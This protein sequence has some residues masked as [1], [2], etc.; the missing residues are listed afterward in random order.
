[1]TNEVVT[2]ATLTY[3]RA[4]LL[5]SQLEASGIECFLSNINVIRSAIGTGVKVKVR[6]SD[7]NNA[8][9][10]VLL[11][12]EEYGKDELETHDIVEDITKVLVP[13]DFSDYSKKAC[14]Y[15]LGIADRLQAEITFMHSYYFDMMPLVNFSEPYTYQINASQS[16][17]DIK[18]R[19]EEEMLGLKEEMLREAH[20]KQYE[21]INL[22]TYLTHGIPDKEI[23][24]YSK[25]Y[26]PGVIIMGTKIHSENSNQF[27]GNVTATVLEE[28]KVPVLTIP[29]KSNFSGVNKTN[30]LYATDFDKSD[31]IAIRKLMTLIYLF[32][33]KIYCVHIGNKE[34]DSVILNNLKNHI[35]EHY[36][37]YDVEYTLIEADNILKGLQSFID[38]KSID[39]I[40]M[41]THK[42]NLITKFLRP[43]LTKKMLFHSN[44]PLLVFHA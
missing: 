44:T 20:E 4:E 35:D 1:M 6:K 9:R 40:S 15:A 23:I 36:S 2:I 12:D 11:H 16:I 22:K 3:S 43:S 28:A 34:W 25:E 8:L 41:T 29:G 37:G 10:I 32:D 42:R 30:I 14:L 39:I 33:V 13:V 27:F 19:A 24:A 21:N 26:N 17:T 18:N 31:F 5:K 38:N 7:M